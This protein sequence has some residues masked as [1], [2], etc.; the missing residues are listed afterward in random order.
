MSPPEGALA[1][2]RRGHE[3]RV[4][5]L[6]RRHGALSR[7]ALGSLSGLSRTTLHDIISGL[8]ASGAIVAAAPRQATEARGRGRPAAS[9]SLNPAAGQAIG[10]DF[11]RRRVHVAI[12]NVAHEIIGSA[13]ADHPAGTPCQRRVEI[14]ERLIGG[15]SEGAVRLGPLRAIGVGV[16]GPVGSP[17][18][19][20]AAA[21]RLNAVPEL[22]RK[23]FG[24][25]ALLDNNTRLAALA[26][27]I[28]GAA[29]GGQDVLYVRLSHGVGGGLVLGGSL[30]R[31][32]Y[33]VAGE[34]GHVT[35]D[36]DGGPCRCG[37][38]G[39]LETIASVKAVL[40]A[41]RRV[42]GRARDL[43][44]LAAALRAGDP[45]ARQV[46]AYA[47]ERVGLVLAAVCNTVG[48]SL[49]VVGGELAELGGTV[50]TEPIERR[51]RAEVMPMMRR[52]LRLRPAR[53]GEVG[54][55]LGGIALVLHA[56]PLLARYPATPDGGEPG[57]PEGLRAP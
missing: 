40:A 31:G 45:A 3:E 57:E 11:A 52:R 17:G 47:G 44:A 12:A 38:R 32:A 41:Y 53:L 10:I 33:G 14:A 15:L 34:V 24:V 39:C 28:W 49:V 30:H 1:Q 35:V 2:L 27:S 13:S 55:A 4:L 6:L 46:L 29:E 54:G 20:S 42:G 9:L 8:L 50:L 25:P 18:E 51:L 23:S 7:S 19:Q 5:D 26:E 56:S 37:G 43:G 22:L 48:P 21:R 16:V 36:P